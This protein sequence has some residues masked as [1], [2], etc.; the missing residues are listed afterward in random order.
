MNFDPERVAAI[1]REVAEEEVLPRF[2]ALADEEI[3]RKKAGDL[4]TVADLA[5]E[6]VLER[7]LPPL[8]PGSLVLGEEAAE[9][10]PDLFERVAG[11]ETVW[12]VDPIDGTGNFARGVAT[13]AVMVAL[14]RGGDL[15][16][17]WILDPVGGRLAVAVSGEG[18]WLDGRRLRVETGRPPEALRGTLHAG[19]FGSPE[20]ARRV[21]RGRAGL[22]VLKS[23]RCAGHEYLRLVTGESDF[24]LFTKTRPWDH[25]AGVLL[26][27]EA[28]GVGRLLDGRPYSARHHSEEGLLMA[29]D[30]AVWQALHDRLL[31]EG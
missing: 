22:S 26:H 6:R 5:V 10:D 4:V 13:F 20:L 1:L 14:T 3:M 17:G 29:P 27:G 12:I 30:A 19:F 21:E 16:G 23:L 25:C 24:T 28:G 11:E 18:A 9:H 8:L 15:L 2:R 31:G 7:R